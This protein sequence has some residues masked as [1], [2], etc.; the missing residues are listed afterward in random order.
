MQVPK[1]QACDDDEQPPSKRRS[2]R[3][4]A[5]AEL[6]KTSRKGLTRERS[7]LQ[8][9]VLQRPSEDE[10]EEEVSIPTPK[11]GKYASFQ[12]G[13]RE[14]EHGQAP[15]LASTEQ[16][17]QNERAP[18][19][20]SGGSTS[21]RISAVVIGNRASS[22]WLSVSSGADLNNWQSIISDSDDEEDLKDEMRQLE[23]KRQLRAMERK[24]QIMVNSGD[25]EEDLKDEMRHLEIKRK[26]RAMEKMRKA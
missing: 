3:P 15:P 25:D 7:W 14:L 21:E 23:I 8:A 18:A 6:S 22:D 11:D 5:N 2:Q 9:G 26:L 13:F 24:S 4:G 17:Q 16:E 19:L 1:R 20:S 10:D 12:H